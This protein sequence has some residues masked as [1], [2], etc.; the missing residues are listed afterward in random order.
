[1]ILK[2]LLEEM[3]ESTLD[4]LYVTKNK[5]GESIKPI[6]RFNANAESLQLAY[7]YLFYGVELPEEK[8][9]DN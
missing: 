4:L 7:D 6:K 9:P 8:D 3:G 1:M 5:Y 2:N